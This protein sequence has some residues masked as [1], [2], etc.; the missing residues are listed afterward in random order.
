M[1]LSPTNVSPNHY[2]AATRIIRSLTG[3]RWTWPRK[4]VIEEYWVPETVSS[5][6]LAGRPVSG[7][8]SVVDRRGDPWQ[9]ELSD[10]FRLR[11]PQLERNEWPFPAYPN[12]DWN[13]GVYPGPLLHRGRHLIIDYVYGAPPPIEVQMAIRELGAE[14]EAAGDPSK[15][16]RLPER[17][18][19]V[20][21]EG[22]SWTVIDPQL[23]LENGKTGLYYP[24]LVISTYGGGKAKLRARV[25]SPEHPP[26]RR[27]SS[28][29]VLPSVLPPGDS[30]D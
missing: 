1:G 17:V 3:S 10:F 30:N 19:S 27:L 11:F 15:T 7:V 4:H 29:V 14:L 28:E 24:D 8:N 5:L 13:G 16:C 25:F 26:P 20:N 18:T 6:S 21:R 23:F 22:V 2:T 9:F 12:Y